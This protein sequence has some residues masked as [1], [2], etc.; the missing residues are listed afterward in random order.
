MVERPRTT[1]ADG[2]RLNGRTS[3]L[4][5]VAAHERQWLT[6]GVIAVTLFATWLPARRAA[7]VDPL[8]TLQVV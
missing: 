1:S 8:A 2:V 3:A 5:V 4:V 6:L 7:S